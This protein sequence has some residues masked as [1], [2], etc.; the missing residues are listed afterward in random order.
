MADGDNIT[1]D[2]QFQLHDSIAFGC[3]GGGI[4][5]DLSA[6]IEGLGVPD[7]KTQDVVYNFR[8][9]SY[10]NPDYL[11]PRVVTLGCM[12]RQSSAAD[13][14]N[15]LDAFNAV[16]VPFAASTE[17]AF[18]L[19]GWGLKKVNGRPRGAKADLTLMRYGVIRFLAR[20]DALDPTIVDL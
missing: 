4:S 20:F 13:A 2:Y 12:I 19:P 5:L 17:L 9:G 6:P 8:D 15:D 14:M 11:K 10:P 1:Q 18:Q 3:G 7:T 16:W